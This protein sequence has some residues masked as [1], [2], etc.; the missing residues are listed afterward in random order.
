MGNTIACRVVLSK[1]L[2]GLKQTGVGTGAYIG[3]FGALPEIKTQ[4]RMDT[5]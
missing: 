4:T 5:P 1:R 2:F 3:R